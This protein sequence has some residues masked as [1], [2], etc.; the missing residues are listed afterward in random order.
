[1]VEGT[2]QNHRSAIVDEYVGGTVHLLETAIGD[3]DGDTELQ[4]NSEA[5]SATV[6]GDWD[7]SHDNVAGTTTLTNS[8]TIDFGSV[9]GFTV[10][11]IAVQSTD[12][13]DHILL[14]DG[15]SGDTDLSGDGDTSIE[16]GEITY[17]L[18]GE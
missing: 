3:D 9:T 13:V 1:M 8:A 18:G 14:D 12:N 17:T 5:N 7:V 2:N 11:Q 4:A 15:P 6:D 10:N 16:P